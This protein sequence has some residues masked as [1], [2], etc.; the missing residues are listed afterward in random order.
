MEP[1]KKGESNK[2]FEYSNKRY[3]SAG[4]SRLHVPALPWRLSCFLSLAI[5]TS[6]V[7]SFVS[8]FL[9]SSNVSA[10]AGTLTISIPD[11][12]SL[13]ILP[14]ASGTFASTSSNI[15]VRTTYA[16]GYTLG[17][18]A[19][20][21]N[22]NALINTSSSSKTIPSITSAISESTFSSSSSYNNKWGYSPSKY[23]SS[24][25]TNYLVAPT[26][27][28]IAT[29]DKTTV[30]NS[31]NNSYAIKL[32]ARIDSTLTPGTYENTFVFTVTANATPYTINYNANTTDT[33]TSMPSPNPQ[34]GETF[35][36]S[37]NISNTTP[38][39]DGYT[40]LG[41]CTAVTPSVTDPSS[42]MSTCAEAGGS[43]Y[44]SGGSWSIDQTAATNALTLYAMWGMD[45]PGECTDRATCMQTITTCSTTPTNVV[46]ARDG[47]TYKMQKLADGNCWL[48]DNLRL[49]PT[50]VT[51]AVLQGNTNAS[52]LALSYLKN[53][54]GSSSDQFATA[55]VTSW[56]SGYSYSAPLVNTSNKNTTASAS[57]SGS[58]KIGVYYNY[59][60][61]SAGTYC[62]GNGTSAGSGFG[63][64]SGDLCPKG[65]RMPIDEF[66]SL[67]DVLG[68]E[69]VYDEE[70]PDPEYVYYSGNELQTAL[71][72]PLSGY[73]YN[74]SVSDKN[75]KGYYWGASSGY[76]AIN[77][78]SSDVYLDSGGL[79]RQ[80]GLPIRCVLDSRT[81]SDATYMQDVT[82]PMI[83]NSPVGT[84]AT[85]TDRRDNE[86]YI[87]SKLKDGN[88]WMLD[89]LRLDPTK[90]YT[91][92]LYKSNAR[93]DSINKLK[94]GG[95]TTSDRYATAAVANWGSSYSFSAPLVNTSYK[96]TTT[97]G[98]GSGSKKM[99]VY[100]NY[101]AAS[102]GSYCFGN[103][104]NAGT[105]SDDTPEDICPS[106]WRMPS[107][108]W[109]RNEY[110]DLGEALGLEIQVFEDYDVEYF[111]DPSYQTALSAT[112]S[113]HID[114]TGT[115]VNNG[116]GG[117]F[118]S[119]SRKDNQSMYAL[120]LNGSDS[121]PGEGLGFDHSRSY[122]YSVRCIFK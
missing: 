35:A 25:N 10:A 59:C 43:L 99:G 6:L 24:A 74:A 85:I 46:D 48:L 27:T 84:V 55:G 94:S 107:G 8:A 40:F 101:C 77:F 87:V 56:V 91:S 119:L 97:T 39:R 114:N 17:I 64:S 61:A 29:L 1:I 115:L 66:E 72:A 100:Y 92:V 117:S 42:I 54:G 34:T 30:A 65:W 14:S 116:S 109:P 19:S 58:K 26:S 20:T 9:I 15:T 4:L 111:D 51:L 76:P 7:F 78:G 120:D 113:G 57:G 108:K 5:I 36:T 21:A 80:Y 49:D 44:W 103:G 118:W 90:V 32:G 47:E 23:N 105:S 63:E 104:T 112:R 3:S 53:G 68:M 96:N 60:A 37:V 86:Q 13:D 95:G 38:T 69:E 11:T 18:A 89:N 45:V 2:Q 81:I 121:F 102:A 33:V 31:T 110:Y 50:S 88:L 106:R 98:S 62:Y 71:S 41:W 82:R 79:N 70:G 12:I 73:Y 22:S 28:T 16:H 93:Y 122:G 67:P 83:D 75:S 52:N